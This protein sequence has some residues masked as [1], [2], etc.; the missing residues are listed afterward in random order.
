MP[1][2]DDAD[3]LAAYLGYKLARPLKLRE[4]L[5]ALQMS[6]TRRHSAVVL[7]F[8]LTPLS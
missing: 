1:D 3:R 8:P 7:R 5:E 2:H 6:K 4:I